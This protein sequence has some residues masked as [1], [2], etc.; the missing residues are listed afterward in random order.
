MIPSYQRIANAE[1]VFLP[2]VV[3]KYRAKREHIFYL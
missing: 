2:Y 3:C 1:F